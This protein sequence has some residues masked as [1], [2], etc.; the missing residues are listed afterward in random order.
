[1][2]IFDCRRLIFPVIMMLLLLP[3][4]SAAQAG[5]TGRLSGVV[6]GA[7]GATI[8]GAEIVATDEQTGAD[9]HT[10]SDRSGAWTISSVPAGTYTLTFTSPATVPGALRSIEVGSGA[11]ATADVTLQ[12]G[13]SETVVVTA[14]RVEQ[15][16]VNAPATVT[17]VNDRR[18]VAEPTQ[19]YADIMREIPGVNVVQMSARDFNVTPRAATSVPAASQ[20]VMIDGRPINQDYYG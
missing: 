6:K 14:S 15:L 19:D 12:L 11:T 7:D 18:I 16:L 4:S 3:Y 13:I 9:F 2:N 8:P 1:M 20:L 5:G 10:F 17:I